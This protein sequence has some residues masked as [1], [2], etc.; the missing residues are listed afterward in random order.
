MRALSLDIRERIVAAI[1]AGATPGAVAT[2]FQVDRSTVYRYVRQQRTTG[3][4]VSHPIPGRPRRI[5]PHAEASLERQLRLHPD[6]TLAEHGEHWMATH[7]EQVSVA[8]LWRAIARIGWTRKKGRR[9][10]ASAPTRSAPPGG[11]VS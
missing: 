11:P 3:V 5:G 4:L 6:A 8:T 1:A 9:R 7:G 10:P 2:R